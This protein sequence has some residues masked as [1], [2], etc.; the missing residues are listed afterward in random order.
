MNEYTP[1]Y[2]ELIDEDNQ[3]RTFEVIDSA[4]INDEQYYFMVPAVEDDNFLNTECEPIIL[5]SV[6]ENGEEFLEYIKD[7]Y[8][9]Q[10]VSD[11][12]LQRMDDYDEYS[13]DYDE[14]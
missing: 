3:K 9:Y 7:E 1:E 10:E 12:F 8:E 11:Y 2:W 13:D 4:V 6:F 5:K 14:D